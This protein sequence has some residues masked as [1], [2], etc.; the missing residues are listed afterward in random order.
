M[1]KKLAKN[2]LLFTVIGA[3]AALI[4]PPVLPA[5]TAALEFIGLNAGATFL[6]VAG[7]AVSNATVAAAAMTVGAIGIAKTL[8]LDP[9]AKAITGHDHHHG[10]GSTH[11]NEQTRTTSRSHHVTRTRS[12]FADKERA[13]REAAQ[14]TEAAHGIG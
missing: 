11:S 6:T 1:L 10:N 14:N 3:A 2:A 9:V 13:R 8:V 7:T 4:F 12:D 5:A